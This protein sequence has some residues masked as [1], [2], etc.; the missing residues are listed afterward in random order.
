M[1]L[2]NLSRSLQE[3]WLVSQVSVR[4]RAKQEDSLWSKGETWSV[5]GNKTIPLAACKESGFQ[6]SELI[7]E[8]P[9]EELLAFLGLWFH[10]P[11][12]HGLSQT[13]EHLVP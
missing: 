4:G 2:C 1:G 10:G 7:Q 9:S 5:G 11:A 8:H 6:G 13:L 3:T 12:Q